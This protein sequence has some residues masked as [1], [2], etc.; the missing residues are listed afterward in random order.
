MRGMGRRIIQTG[1]AILLGLNVAIPMYLNAQ[2]LLP[3]WQWQ[4]H[5]LIGFL[6]FSVFVGRIIFS[7]QS[8]INKLESGRP[9]LT[10]GDKTEINVQLREEES[11][12]VNSLYLRY[13]NTGSRPAYQFRMRVGYAPEGSP[14]EFKLFD[15]N[16]SANPI[17]QS[18]PQ[19]GVLHTF[20]YKYEV[21]DGKKT[22]GAP[23][24]VLIHCALSYSDAPSGGKS[25][26]EEWWY[27][28]RFD[29]QRFSQLSIVRKAELEPHVKL[30]YSKMERAS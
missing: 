10:I 28:Y 17:Y 7:Q 2:G 13:Q 15:E 29:E 21:K 5:A 8:H 16:T 9:Q 25:Y 23:K 3:M 30:A 14:G 19:Q 26:N 4:Y 18:D 1:G 12:E 22:T 11:M 24:G 20:A 6:A 27:S